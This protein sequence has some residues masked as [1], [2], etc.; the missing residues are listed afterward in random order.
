MC[1]GEAPEVERFARQNKDTVRVIGLGTQDTLGLAEDFVADYDTS[2]T[3]LWD[4]SFE[5]WA[6]F[7]VTSQPAAMLFGA[8]GTPIRG[9]LGR[10]PEADVLA[11]AKRS[12]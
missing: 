4:E 10:F 12:R 9:W 6:A 5:S 2:F 7:G 8:D 1:R 11:L 3:M